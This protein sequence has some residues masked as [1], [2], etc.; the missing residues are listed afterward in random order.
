MGMIHRAIS[1]D[2]SR[3]NNDALRIPAG[4][5]RERER[6]TENI[7]SRCCNSA[8]ASSMEKFEPE[9]ND[10]SVHEGSIHEGC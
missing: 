4:K 9:L 1:I 7:L 6:E 2:L 3:C 10:E 5:V 8:E